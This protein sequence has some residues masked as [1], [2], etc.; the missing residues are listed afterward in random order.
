MKKGGYGLTYQEVYLMDNLTIEAKAIYGMLCSYAGAGATA[1]PSVETICRY[2]KISERR[3]Y[4][5]MNLLIGSG[6]VVKQ[7]NR[8]NGRRSN[9]V[10]VLTPNIQNLPVENV[11]VENVSV[12]NV[13]VENVG[14]NN[15]NINNNN[16]N[17]N[18]YNVSP[19]LDKSAPVGSG[20]LI[21]L[22]DGTCYDVPADK[23]AMWIELYPDVDLEQELRRMVMWSE[24]HEEKRKDRSNVVMFID[25]WLRREHEKLNGIQQTAKYNSNNGGGTDRSDE[26]ANRPRYPRD[27]SDIL[28]W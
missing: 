2:L 9:N 24:S 28:N 7:A 6:I 17:N 23:I 3:F 11:S 13:S 4:T 21:P 20:I 12:E 16:I 15:N 22:K 1:Y 26:G 14:T 10:Y 18:S 25:G 8:E 19:E 5:H 27:V